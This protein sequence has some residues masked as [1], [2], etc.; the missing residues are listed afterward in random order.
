MISKEQLL[1][2]LTENMK[3]IESEMLAKKKQGQK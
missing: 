3:R 1:K 2:E